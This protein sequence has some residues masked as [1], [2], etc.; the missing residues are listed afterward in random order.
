M[1]FEL[2]VN[3]GRDALGVP[4]IRRQ[5]SV[6]VPVEVNLWLIRH[7]HFASEPAQD[8]LVEEEDHLVEC[9]YRP[10]KEP[11]KIAKALLDIHEGNGF[12][13]EDVSTAKLLASLL[14]E[15]PITH[16]DVN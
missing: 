12:D 16:Y 3:T 9:S 10:L 8:V 7:N 2:Y 4:V 13:F 15:F 6:F 1:H 14:K 11:E 5:V